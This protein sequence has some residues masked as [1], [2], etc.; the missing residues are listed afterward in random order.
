MC[1][2]TTYLCTAVL[3]GCYGYQTPPSHQASHG[4]S[5]EI[6][7]YS[8]RGEDCMSRMM[9][10]VTDW[11]YGE[12]VSERRDRR[13]EDSELFPALCN[14]DYTAGSLSLV[15]AT[16]NEVLEYTRH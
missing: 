3:G 6:K 8:Q 7:N 2:F 4:I 15:P 5:I 14:T 11:V 10:M 12:I 16:E 13:R 9:M 1:S